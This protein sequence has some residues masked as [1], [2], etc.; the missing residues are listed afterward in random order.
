MDATDRADVVA[1]DL[2]TALDRTTDLTDDAVRTTVRR[3]LT[4]AADSALATDWVAA[5]RYLTAVIHLDEQAAPIARSFAQTL[6]FPYEV[7][8]F[9]PSEDARP[10]P[11]APCDE[12]VLQTKSVRVPHRP[13]DDVVTTDGTGPTGI[14]ESAAQAL[15]RQSEAGLINEILAGGAVAASV[16][17]AASVAR[18]KLEATTQRRKDTLEAETERLRIASDERVARLQARHGAGDEP[19]ADAEG[20]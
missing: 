9:G 16:T 10:R 2:R 1:R 11:H 6:G 4:A 7:T 12:D 14:V 19:E 5:Q 13:A 8:E 3:L 20:G 18:A 17:A 15:A